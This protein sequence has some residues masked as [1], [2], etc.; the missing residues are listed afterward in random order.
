MMK[1]G[2]GQGFRRLHGTVVPCQQR[3]VGAN[4]LVD[5]G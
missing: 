5:A 4:K 2:F 3:R 1:T